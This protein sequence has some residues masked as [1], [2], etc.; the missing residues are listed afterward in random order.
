MGHF[1]DTTLKQQINTTL[2]KDRNEEAKKQVV[3]DRVIYDN[4][5]GILTAKNV[6]SEAPAI[7]GTEE[8]MELDKK[9]FSGE[10]ADLFGDMVIL[11]PVEEI[12]RNL[13]REDLNRYEG[14]FNGEGREFEDVQKQKE[15]IRLIRGSY[16]LHSLSAQAK[17]SRDIAVK[18]I[19]ADALTKKQ[20]MEGDKD[21]HYVVE[22]FISDEE[23]S[24]VALET[25]EFLEQFWNLKNALSA[26]PVLTA[27]DKAEYLYNFSKNFAYDVEVYKDLYFSDLSKGERKRDI[28]M[29]IDRFESL[30]TYFHEKEQGK[31]PNGA[32]LTVI[33]LRLGS[34]HN[35]MFE[36]SSDV[37]KRAR[38]R[39]KRIDDH[40][41]KKADIT[42]N[43]PEDLVIKRRDKLD[44]T[45][46]KEQ[47][48]GVRKADKWLIN[49]GINSKKRLPFIN[50][51]MSLSARERLFIYRILETDRLEAPTVSDLAVSQTS[52]VPDTAAINKQ[53]RRIPWRIWEKLGNEGMVRHHWEKLEAALQLLGHPEVAMGIDRFSEIQ[54]TEASKRAEETTLELWKNGTPEEKEMYKKATHIL[55]LSKERNDLMDEAIEALKVCEEKISIRDSAWVHKK[56]KSDEADKAIENAKDILKKLEYKD[57]DLSGEVLDIIEIKDKYELDKKYAS[58]YESENKAD[59]KEYGMYASSQALTFLAKIGNIPRLF[60]TESEVKAIGKDAVEGIFKAGNY[61]GGVFATLKGVQGIVQ[62]L[63]A[64]K[65][66]YDAIMTGDISNWDS[67]YII[68]SSAI[69]LTNS[70]VATGVGL[71]NIVFASA[72]AEAFL[73]SERWSDAIG[74]M[75]TGVKTGVVMTGTLGLI[76]NAADYAL[77]A[78]H[79]FRHQRKASKM[80]DSMIEDETLT[81][82]DKEYMT[83]ISA[84]SIRNKRRKA[85]GTA[86]SAVTNAG[87][88]AAAFAGPAGSIAW[89]VTSIGISV[90]NKLTDYLMMESSKKKTAE[91]FMQLN[92][93]QSLINEDNEDYLREQAISSLKEEKFSEKYKDDHLMESEDYKNLF[94]E[95]SKEFT[96]TE[97]E[98]KTRTEQ[99]REE[100]SIS[101]SVQRSA[102]REILDSKE[103]SDA[104]KESLLNHMA[105]ELGFVTFKSLY[106]HIVGNYAAFLY[107]GL[108]YNGPDEAITAGNEKDSPMS[109]ACAQLVR[110]LGLKVEYPTSTDPKIAEKQR[111]PSAAMIS[112]KLGA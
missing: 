78:E 62:S 31:K 79:Y 46:S 104:L 35:D 39:V 52:Y 47:L 5:A 80:I 6:L 98:I 3:T 75:K 30:M 34:A 26:D 101:M 21:L 107:R 42:P 20:L 7:F 70:I 67:A 18:G 69:S 110:S 56:S 13:V 37:L 111:H 64:V 112:K 10:N 106:K 14:F 100:R 44:S 15:K 51:I 25:K 45:L 24:R 72:T 50:R 54:D 4:K 94:S 93:L 88:I 68:G 49:I 81:G 40:V 9:F 28:E 19:K 63:I 90:A 48:L 61:A 55:S 36:G 1:V 41:K 86:F 84:L 59:L 77:Q 85:L 103:K 22:T 87:N 29:Y 2:H 102:I 27:E 97:E 11:Q 60:S 23:K 17:L 92:D 109:E 53:F 32:L 105:A 96:L 71:T 33:G 91:E 12:S 8:A 65:K 83:G 58:A 38:T 74:F 99:F 89:S 66:G 76:S 82:D 43:P 73:G 16:Q 95:G 108:F 57:Y